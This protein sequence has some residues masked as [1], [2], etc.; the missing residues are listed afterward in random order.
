MLMYADSPALQAR[1]LSALM[2]SQK[3]FFKPASSQRLVF[4]PANHDVST[5]CSRAFQCCAACVVCGMSWDGGGEWADVCG[6]SFGGR[7]PK[8]APH[9]QKIRRSANPAARAL[10]TPKRAYQR[11]L[12]RLPP[13]LHAATSAASCSRLARLACGV[14]PRRAGRCKTCE[15][16][17][18]R[19]RQ[20]RSAHARV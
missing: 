13:T 9:W 1:V 7:P 10:P 19:G 16:D 4:R 3:S 2:F 20:I 18:A 17:G 12:S 6:G 14:C 11:A 8:T 5:A 15:L